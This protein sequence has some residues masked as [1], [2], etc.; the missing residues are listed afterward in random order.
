MKSFN[1]FLNN[2]IIFYCC[3]FFLVLIN[4]SF[5]WPVENARITSSFGESR[6]DHFHSGI[7]LISGTTKIYPVEEGELVFFWDKSAFPVENYP[8]GGNYKIIRHKSGYYSVYMHLDD[9][10]SCKSIYLNNDPV[11]EMGSTGH[12]SGKHLHF[13]M[14]QIESNEYINPLKIFPGVSDNMKPE[15]EGVYIRIEDKYFRI[16]ENDNIRLTQHYPLLINIWD[17]VNKGDRLGIYKLRISFNG[18]KIP[19]KDY[20]EISVADNVSKISGMVFDEL[21]DEKGYYKVSEIKYNDGINTLT[22]SAADF[23]GN[24]AGKNFSFTVNL[25]MQ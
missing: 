18:E 8:G 20:S 9:N 23:S 10:P 17:S 7:D 13:S 11:G 22:V 5:S 25:D 1:I 14:Y 16:K 6:G 19:D 21:F 2:K 12:S 4:L 24:E 15:I 3:L